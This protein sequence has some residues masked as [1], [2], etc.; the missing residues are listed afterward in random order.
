MG[1]DHPNGRRIDAVKA[2]MAHVSLGYRFVFPI[3]N[4]LP[5]TKRE[6][7]DSDSRYCNVL[8]P[9]LSAKI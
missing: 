6:C 4:I 5:C 3:E 2:K 1:S 7:K 9:L 8:P